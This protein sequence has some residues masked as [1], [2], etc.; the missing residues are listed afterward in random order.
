MDI[1]FI[2]DAI[3]ILDIKTKQMERQRE[4][5]AL[6]HQRLDRCSREIAILLLQ[7]RKYHQDM[8]KES[9]NLSVIGK[10]RMGI[11]I[12]SDWES[13][14]N[15]LEKSLSQDQGCRGLRKFIKRV[16]SIDV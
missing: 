5:D 11:T 15:E 4:I 7:E 10:L 12:T 1:F 14:Y 13:R 2:K 16:Y 9:E 6:L 3:K 8:A